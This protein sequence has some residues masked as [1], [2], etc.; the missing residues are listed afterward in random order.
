MSFLHR[1]FLLLALTS[2]VTGFSSHQ[3]STRT[4][5]TSSLN[6]ER[7]EFLIAGAAAVLFTAAS[8]ANAKQKMDYQAGVSTWDGVPLSAKEAKTAD[9]LFSKLTAAGGSSNSTSTKK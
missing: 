3:P 9:D 4:T 2:L 5:S 1:A 8:P 6:A 7:R